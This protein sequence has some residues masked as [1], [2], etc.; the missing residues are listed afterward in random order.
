MSTPSSWAKPRHFSGTEGADMKN[1]T[2]IGTT[3]PK[4][5]SGNMENLLGS[6]K[7]KRLLKHVHTKKRRR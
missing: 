4:D 5:Q 6:K 7:G 3:T 1:F 2:G